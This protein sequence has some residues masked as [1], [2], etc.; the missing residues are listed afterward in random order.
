M[1][2][3]SI[4]KINADS[5]LIAAALVDKLKQTGEKI[6]FAESCTAGLLAGT[7][8]TVAGASAVFDGSA[9]TYANSCKTEFLGVSEELLN[10]VGAV[11]NACAY[12]MAKGA[13]ARFGADL[14]ISVTGIAGPGGGSKEKPVGTVFIGCCYHGKLSS[15]H[16]L[17]AGDR[18]QVRAQSVR[19]ALTMALKVLNKE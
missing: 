13:A 17:F 5:E 4:S 11:S 19:E 18:A 8:C 7:F 16:C 15:K 9:V 2:E 6:T 10:T 12:Q 14:A 1:D 3:Q